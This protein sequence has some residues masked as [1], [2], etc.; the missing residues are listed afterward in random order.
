MRRLLILFSFL[1]AA[2]VAAAQENPSPLDK[3]YEEARAAYNALRAADKR[4]PSTLAA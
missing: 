1:L 4:P 2:G 3:A